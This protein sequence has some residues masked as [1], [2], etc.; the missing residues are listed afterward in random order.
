MIPGASLSF[1]FRL[2][3][4]DGSPA[5]HS[6]FLDIIVYV[7]IYADKVI[8]F[9]KSDRYNPLVLLNDNELRVD[10][11][12]EQT[13]SLGAGKPKFSIYLAIPAAGFPDGKLVFK[14]R[15]DI[16]DTPLEPDPISVE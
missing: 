3:N 14:G 13:R 6:D 1:K 10:C 5:K 11:S 7:Y 9:S 2:I 16:L 4:D 15:C 12:P 8:K